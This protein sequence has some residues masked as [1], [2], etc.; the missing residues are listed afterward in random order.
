MVGLGSLPSRW[1]TYAL[2]FG[3]MAAIL[4]AGLALPEVF[5]HRVGT[6]AAPAVRTTRPALPPGPPRDRDP[7]AVPAYA[8]V[9]L[10]TGNRPPPGQALTASDVGVTPSS[11]TIGIIL[12]SLGAIAAFGIDVS[13]LDPKAQEAYWEAAVDRINAAGGVDGRRLDV[14]YATASI[15]SA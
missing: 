13:Q 6:G 7:R 9:G 14:V 1:A 15:I 2:L 8:T 10:V 11:I 4:A 5:G 12:P 3:S